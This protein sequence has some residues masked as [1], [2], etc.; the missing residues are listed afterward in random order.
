MSVRTYSGEQTSHRHE[1]DQIILPLEGTLTLAVGAREG[2]VRRLAGGLVRGGESHAFAAK[3][4]N[5]FVVIDVDTQELSAVDAARAWL[6]R[7]GRGR[8]FFDLDPVLVDTARCAAASSDRSSSSLREEWARLLVLM[9]AERSVDEP[10]KARSSSR[11]RKILAFIEQNASRQLTVAEMAAVAELGASQVHWLF[12]HVVGCTPQEYAPRVRL[13][14]ARNAVA[15][16]ERS[17]ASIALDWGY[18]DQASFTRAFRRQFGYT[19]GAQRRVE[20]RSKR[21]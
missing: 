21:P 14:G 1:W 3:G 2:R 9:I 20:K 6:D 7:V 4:S 19:P 10:A 13:V 16:T 17:L 15:T 5:R 8:I 12:R 11:L 18:A